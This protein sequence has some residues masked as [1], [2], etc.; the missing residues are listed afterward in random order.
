MG[1]TKEEKRNEKIKR[2]YIANLKEHKINA[3][4]KVKYSIERFD[5]LIISLSS[6]GLALGSNLITIYKG[7][8][9]SVLNIALIFFSSA[10]II[11]LLSQITGYWAN[12]YD[13][14]CTDMVIDEEEGE[15]PIGTH[16]KLDCRKALCTQLTSLLNG[17]S[18][19]S[20]TT[21][22]ILIIIFI[23]LKN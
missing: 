11:N 4:A 14:K 1:K 7:Q 22:I 19:I 3:K 10:L 20:L 21:G 6:G 16:K 9:L 17:L 13:I 5:I 18:F 23:N 2:R 12:K 15:L 8:D